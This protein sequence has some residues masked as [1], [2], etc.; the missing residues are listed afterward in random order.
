MRKAD[1]SVDAWEMMQG[2]VAAKP[3]R[4]WEII[5]AAVRVAE[6]DVDLALIGSGLL[7]DLLVQ[8]SEFLPRALQLACDDVSFRKALHSADIRG[9]SSDSDQLDDF[10]ERFGFE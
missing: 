9:G 2:I 7:E 1:P 10:F 5:R 3:E 4:A 6:D 8:H